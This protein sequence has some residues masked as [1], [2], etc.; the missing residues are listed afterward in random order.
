MLV[1]RAKKAKLIVYIFAK[2][3]LFSFRVVVDNFVIPFG[4]LKL[5]FRTLLLS[6]LLNLS[7]FLVTHIFI[8]TQTELQQI[9]NLALPI[10]LC[11]ATKVIMKS[12][13]VISR[14]ST[15]AFEMSHK[16]MSNIGGHSSVKQIDLDHIWGDLNA[17]I[18]RVYEGK[19]MPKQRYMQLYT[20]VYNYCTSVHQQ[21]NGRNS[22][23]LP[24][25]GKSKKNQSNNGGAQLVG[26][27]L[28]K[29]LREFMRSY[30][31]SLLQV[32]NFFN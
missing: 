11:F 10:V 23:S 8:L 24:G 22:T 4:R 14:R 19:S 6:L 12:F 13:S 15:L 5:K 29:R 17:G 16:N 26:L 32:S 25:S 30:L 28:Y 2:I 21:T 31:I 7:K 27:E 3:K 18:D 9:E 1:I 20:H